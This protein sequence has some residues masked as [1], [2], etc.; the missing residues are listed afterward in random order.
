MTVCGDFLTKIFCKGY[1]IQLIYDT[2]LLKKI[3]TKSGKDLN[4]NPARKIYIGSAQQF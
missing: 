2:F 4:K 3:S 1:F